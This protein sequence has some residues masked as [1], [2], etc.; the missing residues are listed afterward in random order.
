MSPLEL[1]NNT[2]PANDSTG[3]GCNFGRSNLQ[4]NKSII[5]EIKFILPNL[6]L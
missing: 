5:K 2:V 4:D 6:N 3:T 1:S